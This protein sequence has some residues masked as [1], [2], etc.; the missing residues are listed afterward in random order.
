MAAATGGSGAAGGDNMNQC[1]INKDT[2]KV[3]RTIERNKRVFNET[4]VEMPSFDG[5]MRIFEPRESHPPVLA[6]SATS[7]W[8]KVVV[9]SKDAIIMAWT[10]ISGGFKPLI[11][12][13]SCNTNR[14]GGAKEGAITVEAELCRRCHHRRR[15][16]RSCRGKA[17]TIPSTWP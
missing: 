16:R 1:A 11:V 3:I 10:L 15:R 12:Y 5:E 17:A 14:G 9:N 2:T 4:Y 6:P 8:P 7:T 13:N